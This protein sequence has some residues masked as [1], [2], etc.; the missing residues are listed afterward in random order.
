MQSRP[1]GRPKGSGGSAA[2]LASNDVQRSLKMAANLRRHS[3]RAELAILISVEF[4]LS[5][6]ALSRLSVGRIFESG[7]ALNESALLNGISL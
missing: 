7:G 6:G 1:R 5:A 4:G 2:I 3:A